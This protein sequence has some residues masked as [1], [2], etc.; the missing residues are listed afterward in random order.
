[1][2]MTKA[3]KRKTRTYSETERL[4][5]MTVALRDGVVAASKATQIPQRTL[6]QWFYDAGGLA[7]IRAYASAAADRSLSMAELAVCNE[8]ARR[9]GL[10][11]MADDELMTT[12]RALVTARAT[13]TATAG[14]A[15]GA[16]AG[17]QASASVIN[18][19]VQEK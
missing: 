18:V 9:A 8:V 4:G 14:A 5:A 12:F 19:T 17:A 3:T 10:K 13:A 2:P 16:E 11:E 6:N 7:E 1:M 15:A